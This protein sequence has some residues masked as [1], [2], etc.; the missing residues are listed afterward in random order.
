MFHGSEECVD[1][2]PEREPD[3]HADGQ[4]NHHSGVRAETACVPWRRHEGGVGRRW[5]G[6]IRA[7][8]EL[9]TPS[10]EVTITNH[11]SELSNYIVDVNLMSADG[12]TRLD[13]AMVSAEALAPG[14]AI[15]LT[16]RFMTTQ[17]LPTGARLTVAGIARLVA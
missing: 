4:P 3:E 8:A 17:K 13:A 2:Q 6:E 7:D 14:Q 12:K 9:G 1:Q 5:L 10:A 16:A 11:S 15:K